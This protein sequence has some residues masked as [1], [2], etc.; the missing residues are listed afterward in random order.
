MQLN[1]CDHQLSAVLNVK[2]SSA[3]GQAYHQFATRRAV[4]CLPREKIA[5]N[6]IQ[7]K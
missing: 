4:E 6:P 5:S 3:E 7:T 1:S 2:T